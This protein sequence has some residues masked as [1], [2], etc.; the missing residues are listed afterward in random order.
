MMPP[1]VPLDAC[2][3]SV[4]DES[5]GA[6]RTRLAASNPLHLKSVTP[7]LQAPALPVKFDDR[8]DP[9][10]SGRLLG[11]G[12]YSPPIEVKGAW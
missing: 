1:Q 2:W 8:Q 4:R 7:G 12:S 10:Q 9:D 3:R 11:L 5:D 6:A